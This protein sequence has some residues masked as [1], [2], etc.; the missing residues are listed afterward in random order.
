MSHDL[1]YW[2]GGTQEERLQADE[3]LKICVESIGEPEIAKIMLA[4]V[5]VGGTPYLP[6]SFRWGYGWSESRGYKALNIEEK[7]EVVEKLKVLRSMIDDSLD[8]LEEI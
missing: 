7:Q 8:K 3:A 5:R 4:G 6:T 1:A 2:K